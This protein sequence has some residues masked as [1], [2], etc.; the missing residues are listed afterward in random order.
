[1]HVNRPLALAAMVLL[2]ATASAQTTTIEVAPGPFLAPASP[3]SPEI[4][5]LLAEMR[6][7][8]RRVDSA[9]LNVLHSSRKQGKPFQI[10]IDISF[11]KP[12]RIRAKV[13]KGGDLGDVLVITDGKKVSWFGGPDGPMVDTFDPERFPV[14]LNLETLCLW[15]YDRQLSTGKGGNMRLSDLR[16]LRDQEWNGQKWIL[17]EEAAPNVGVFVRYW[18]DPM[19]K[20]IWRTVVSPINKRDQILNE[21]QLVRFD[22]GVYLPDSLFR[23]FGG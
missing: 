1:M 3:K 10:V 13:P 6:E 16:I 2:A 17:L 12:N 22:S 15:D 19:S 14:S 5:Q 20:L 9:K 11:K 18:I 7:A 4:E 21:Y 23:V 8:Y